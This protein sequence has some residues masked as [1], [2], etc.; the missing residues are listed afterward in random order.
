LFG[1]QEID[2]RYAIA[3]ARGNNLA[4][5]LTALPPNKLDARSYR[6]AIA[7][8]AKDHGLSMRWLDERALKRLGANA[9]LAV[10]AGNVDREAGIVH[11]R[12]SPGRRPGGRPDVA[13]VGKGILFDTGGTNLK[14]HRPMLDMHTDMAGGAVALAWLLGPAELGGPIAAE[15]A[16]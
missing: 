12:Y 16:L 1:D 4:R 11:L 7:Q 13:L 3:A 2:L 15:A 6:R 8:L 5:W 10:A 9:F 14:P